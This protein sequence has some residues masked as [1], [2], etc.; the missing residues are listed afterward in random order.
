MESFWNWKWLMHANARALFFIALLILLL[1]LGWCVW[2]VWHPR[3]P[4]NVETGHATQPAQHAE[5]AL[6]ILNCLSNE[7][8]VGTRVVPINPFRPTLESLAASHEPMTNIFV[9]TRTRGGT[10]D[11]FAAI[12][13]QRNVPTANTA[14]PAAPRIP[15]LT[16]LGYFQ[17]P[18][19]KTAALF[20]DSTTPTP[21]FHLPGD[22]F[23]GVALLTSGGTKLRVR[24]PGGQERDLAVGESFELPAEAQP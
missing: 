24:L 9:R 23:H 19:G 18:D 1:V 20:R 3:Q 4:A 11:P 8:A 12:R 2:V 7:L 5:M 17:R 6:G 22:E 15:K 13:G 10:N 14:E 21:V 16:Y